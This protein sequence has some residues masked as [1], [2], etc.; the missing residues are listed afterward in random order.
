V[1][2]TD[3]KMLEVLSQTRMLKAFALVFMIRPD[4]RIIIRVHWF[5]MRHLHLFGIFKKLDRTPSRSQLTSLHPNQKKA[6]AS[7]PHQ[8]QLLR[9]TRIHNTQNQAI[10][11]RLPQSPGQTGLILGVRI[12]RIKS[13]I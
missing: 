13:T 6:T 11:D 3:C 8:S 4:L 2:V 7:A 12:Q 10:R 9:L 5:I 1:P